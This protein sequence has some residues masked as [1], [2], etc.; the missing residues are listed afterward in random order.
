MSLILASNGD[1]LDELTSLT[2]FLL[3]S[4]DLP[5]SVALL[6]LLTHN[7]HHLLQL[8]HNSSIFSAMPPLPFLPD[9]VITEIVSFIAPPPPLSITSNTPSLLS[10]LLHFYRTP[11]SLMD[12]TDLASFW[13][14]SKRFK[15]SSQ[16]KL[17]MNPSV[18]RVAAE[19]LSLPP[20]F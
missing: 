10:A 19:V 5:P 16:R 12:R 1:L 17:E 7:V 6:L 4:F 2:F 15:V 14:S 13:K 9:D 18:Q 11:P 20:V 3:P 8:K